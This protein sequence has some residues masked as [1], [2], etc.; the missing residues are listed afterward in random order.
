MSEARSLYKQGF[1]AFAGGDTETAIARYREAVAQ[2]PSLAIAW[3]GLSLALRKAGDLDGAL[4]AAR[5]LIELEPE[6]ALSHTNLSILLQMKGMIP[7]A[8]DAK[9]Q[10]MQLEMKANRAR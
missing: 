1:A 10:A 6:D 9:A 4:E 8:E 7:E 5:R 2:D 3:N